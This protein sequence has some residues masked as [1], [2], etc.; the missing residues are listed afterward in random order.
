MSEIQNFI[1]R[2]GIEKNYHKDF[3]S[4]TSAIEKS[5]IHKSI[6]QEEFFLKN[7]ALCYNS[8][9]N[10]G[11][12]DSN[13]LQKLDTN[14]TSKINPYALQKLVKQPYLYDYVNLEDFKHNKST[15]FLENKDA[16]YSYKKLAKVKYLDFKNKHKTPVMLTMTLPKEYRKYVKKN[17]N[18][19]STLGA[20]ENLKLINEEANL[21]V[22]IEKSYEK[23]NHTYREFYKYF[24]TLNLRSKEED[25]LDFILIFEPHKSLT[26]HLHVLFYCNL[27]QLENLYR[28]WNNYLRTLNQY[29]KRAQD[30]KII[31]TNRAKAS[32]YLSKYL[33]KEYNTNKEDN[34]S[35]FQKFRRYFSKYKLFRTSNF[36]STTQAKIDKMYSFFQ[37]EYPDILERLKSTEIPLYVI[38]EE[39]EQEGLF[40]FTIK[41][42]K[43]NTYDKALIKK[44]FNKH[45]N[46]IPPKQLKQKMLNNVDEFI[47]PI[48]SSFIETAIFHPKQSKLYDIMNKFQI[49]TDGLEN[50]HHNTDITFY[51]K[52][53]YQI[54]KNTLQKVLNIVGLIV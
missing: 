20:F 13:S 34:N 37:K 32:T 23:L 52:G 29:Q 27:L 3:N 40:S 19:D 41:K 4:L 36:Y 54:E 31:D 39:L 26:I 51:V 2:L 12:L 18:I 11:L 17:R 53:M 22:L 48:A 35:F 38:L 9:T 7:I 49:L 25:K 46:T 43:K 14:Y 28:A 33:V 1:S 8:K 30:F 5:Y 50:L 42:K 45:K 6:N 10:E 15:S 21:E 16:L 47:K 44:Y 24:K